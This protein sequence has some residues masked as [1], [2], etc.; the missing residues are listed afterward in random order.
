MKN[1]H[2]GSKGDKAASSSETGREGVATL[3]IWTARMHLVRGDSD[4]LE[5]QRSSVMGESEQLTSAVDEQLLPTGRIE[6]T[7]FVAA[8]TDVHVGTSRG[9][10]HAQLM[11]S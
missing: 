8:A 3:S 6:K 9:V 5:P 10:P 2:S 11:R 1:R 7:P 4:T